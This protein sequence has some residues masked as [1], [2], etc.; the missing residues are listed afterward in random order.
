MRS[1]RAVGRVTPARDYILEI[2]KEGLTGVMEKDT[3][4]GRMKLAVRNFVPEP[5]AGSDE[6]GSRRP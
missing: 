2:E 5:L 4:V 6:A 3:T 1:R